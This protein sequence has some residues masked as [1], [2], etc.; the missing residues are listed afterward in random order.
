MNIL[1]TGANGQLGRELRRSSKGSAHHFIFSDV[2]ELPGQETVYLDITNKDAL[3]LIAQ[4]EKIDVFINCAAYTAVDRAE[5]DV[6]MADLLNHYA[7]QNLAEVAS[8][9]KALLIHIST[10][11]I[12]CGT[13]HSTPYK[14]CDLAEPCNVYGSTKLAG[15]R[16]ITR[17]GCRYIII[18]TA[19]L[20]S[21]HGRNFVKTMLDMLSGSKDVRVVCDSVGSPTYAGDLAYVIMHIIEQGMLDKT[22]IYHYT[23]EGV[24]SWYDFAQAI[25]ELSGRPAKV[26]AIKNEDFPNAARR[27]SYSV[28]D[29]TLIKETFS[30]EIPYWRDSLK[31]CIEE[32]E[33]DKQ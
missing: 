14:E 26:V 3:R 24:A 11:Y 16:S 19:W 2:S 10:D 12:F 29:K 23:D 7:A 22:G 1:V 15:E 8:E 4:S 27:P 33:A 31:K 25:K 5:A 21:I 18:R 6:Q 20:Y 9:T 17:S 32:Y 28:L 30:I 13:K